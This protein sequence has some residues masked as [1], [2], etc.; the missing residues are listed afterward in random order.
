MSAQNIRKDCDGVGIFAAV[1]HSRG[2]ITSTS[3]GESGGPALPLGELFPTPLGDASLESS[4][5]PPLSGPRMLPESGC[6][7]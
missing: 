4:S 3:G 7:S 2:K 5:V 1:E 6:E